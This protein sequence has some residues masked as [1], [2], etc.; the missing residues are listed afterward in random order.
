MSRTE[1]FIKDINDGKE[2]WILGVRL[3]DMWKTGLGRNEH[4][5][6]LI[7]DKQVEYYG[8][9]LYSLSYSFIT[10][11][12]SRRLTTLFFRV[13]I[14]KSYYHLIS[15]HYGNP[16]FKRVVLISCKISKFRKMNLR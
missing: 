1:D 3:E 10:Q 12:T 11:L 13:T 6:F 8:L 9:S 14:F 5:E 15:A 2:L 7:L 4:L 16:N